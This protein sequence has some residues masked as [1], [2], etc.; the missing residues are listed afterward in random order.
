MKARLKPLKLHHARVG[1]LRQSVCVAQT[2]DSHILSSVMPNLTSLG[3]SSENVL[4]GLVVSLKNDD[5]SLG[6]DCEDRLV[7]AWFAASE[8][9]RVIC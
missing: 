6:I 1:T 4:V 3:L 7:S 2:A 5:A 8:I 9:S